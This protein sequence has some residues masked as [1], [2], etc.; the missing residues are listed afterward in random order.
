MMSSSDDVVRGSGPRDF[1]GSKS[2]VR[3][4]NISYGASGGYL[5]DLFDALHVLG[6]SADLRPYITVIKHDRGMYS[7]LIALRCVV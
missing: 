4:R 2:G 6:F 7:W 1:Y 3:V 5:I